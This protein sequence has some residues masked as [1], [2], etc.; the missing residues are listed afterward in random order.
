MEWEMGGGD[1][2]MHVFDVDVW[3]HFYTLNM[4]AMCSSECVSVCLNM[5]FWKG[6]G[7]NRW[8]HI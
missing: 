5:A 6:R 3:C 7:I 8:R 2:A 1:T 4:S